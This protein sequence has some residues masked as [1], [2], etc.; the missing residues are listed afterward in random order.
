MTPAVRSPL[1][2]SPQREGD[3]TDRVHSSCDGPVVHFQPWDA[4]IF[5]LLVHRWSV[6]VC[7]KKKLFTLGRV[8]LG[9]HYGSLGPVE[10]SG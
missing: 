4:M 2:S 1:N 6:C 3:G 7:E 10:N 9:I 5:S 8:P